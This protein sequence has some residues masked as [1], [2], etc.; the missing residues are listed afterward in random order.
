M[1]FTEYEDRVNSENSQLSEEEEETKVIL[2]E[3]VIK[4]Y[5]MLK[6][7]RPGTTNLSRSNILIRRKSQSKDIHKMKLGDFLATKSTS[8]IKRK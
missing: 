2:D 4:K 7:M 5:L 1:D 6:Y 3:R 8:P